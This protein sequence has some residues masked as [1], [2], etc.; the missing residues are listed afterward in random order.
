MFLNLLF[1]TLLQF[2]SDQSHYKR[3]DILLSASRRAPRSAVLFTAEPTASGALLVT[4]TQ[5]LVV[6]QTTAGGSV[7]FPVQLIL[8]F[9][10]SCSGNGMW[11][12]VTVSLLHDTFL[13]P[14]AVGFHL[15]EMVSYIEGD[16]VCFW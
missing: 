16:S 10:T 9:A 15:F 13:T 12:E 1:P 3:H 4:N 7:D 8:A 2:S 5:L 11:V 14:D 6:E